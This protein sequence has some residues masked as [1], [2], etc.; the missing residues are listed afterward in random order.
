MNINLYICCEITSDN[1]AATEFR[2]S[3]FRIISD[4]VKLDKTVSTSE[5]DYIDRISDLYGITDEDRRLSHSMTLATAL[6]YIS[7]QGKRTKEKM[8]RHM[9][10]CAMQDRNCCRD[11]AML[12][13]AA[14]IICEGN[15]HIISLPINNRPLLTT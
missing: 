14:E 13:S 12:I 9:T 3:V 7:R 2:R 4:L 8:I 15:G 11:E 6:D 1:M 10:D 5:L